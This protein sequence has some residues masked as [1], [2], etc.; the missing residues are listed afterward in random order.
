MAKELD[1]ILDHG[2]ATHAASCLTED[3]HAS[4][5]V[6]VISPIYETMAAVSSELY[7]SF[8]L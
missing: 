5:L 4:F 6:Q 3:G 2:E 7:S 8:W 1:A